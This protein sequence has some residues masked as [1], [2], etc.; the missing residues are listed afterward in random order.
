M[1]FP[2]EGYTTIAFPDAKLDGVLSDIYK[3]LF[4]AGSSVDSG[5]SDPR[6]LEVFLE[7]LSGDRL[8]AFR[9]RVITALNKLQVNCR[10]LS[11]VQRQI[12]EW[13]GPDLLVQR[14]VNLVI[15]PPNDPNPSEL[16]RDLPGNSPFELVLWVPLTDCFG[17]MSMY[18]LNADQS[19]ASSE[20]LKNNTMTWKN[21]E[22]FTLQ[23]SYSIDLRVGQAIVFWAGLWH[24][25]KVNTEKRTRLSINFRVK[26]LFS[27]SGRKD[28]TNYFDLYSSSNITKLALRVLE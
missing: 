23:N 13:L 26:S 22:E 19:L 3:V 15:Q 25:S 12:V 14:G 5:S 4:E 17:T 28:P 16:H 11:Q 8:N 21:F 18:F 27:P 10:L 1:S 6:E 24:G 2:V 9:T 20:A 7:R